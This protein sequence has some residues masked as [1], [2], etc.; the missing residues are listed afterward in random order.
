MA[1]PWLMG[2]FPWCCAMQGL[3]D[4]Q[5]LVLLGLNSN[6]SARVLCALRA[7]VWLSSI[8]G[9]AWWRSMFC[10]SRVT[11]QNGCGWPHAFRRIGDTGCQ[12]FAAS[13]RENSTLQKLLL[14]FNQIGDSGAQS[15]AVA[16][17][18]N[19]VLKELY[20]SGNKF[21]IKGAESLATALRYNKTLELLH[22][23]ANS[24]G[25]VGA[26]ALA[27]VC[28]PRS[29]SQVC[30]LMCHPSNIDGNLRRYRV[31]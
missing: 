23:N 21:G 25:D 29:A 11:L 22:L 18:S 19:T 31:H 2:A 1:W 7:H 14:S 5:S 6:R 15:L 4:N 8:W 28:W 3:C 17:R 16:V 10:F 27:Q 20:M 13:L 9:S 12:A 26:K 24:L 30:T